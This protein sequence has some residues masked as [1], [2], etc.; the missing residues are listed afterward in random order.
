MSERIAPHLP[1]LLDGGELRGLSPAWRFL[2]YE[3]RGHHGV[4]IDG[5]EP[6]KPLRDDERDR[7]VQSRLTLQLYLNSQGPGADEFAG[8]SATFFRATGRDDK[9]Y[10]KF[11]ETYEYKPEERDCLIWDQEEPSYQLDYAPHQL[12]ANGYEAY[13]GWHAGE[14]VKS[15]CKVVARTVIGFEFRSEADA[16]DA[17]SVLW[18]PR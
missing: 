12:K 5:R 3:T 17:D 9:D 14:L 11:E 6:Q 2:R 10:L 18:L 7:Y 4:H 1:R 8:G 13:T 16:E 15:G